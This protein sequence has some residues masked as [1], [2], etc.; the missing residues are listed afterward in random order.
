MRWNGARER[1]TV[2]APSSLSV[3]QSVDVLL[4]TFGNV[5]HYDPDNKEDDAYEY[6]VEDLLVG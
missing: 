4:S 6:Q 5:V 2:H 3:C 1:R